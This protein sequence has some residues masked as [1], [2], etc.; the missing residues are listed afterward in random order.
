MSSRRRTAPAS[1]PRGRRSAGRARPWR[2]LAFSHCRRRARPVQPKP[3][4]SRRRPARRPPRAT[5]S[6]RVRPPSVRDASSPSTTLKARDPPHPLLQEAPGAAR[7]VGARLLIHVSVTTRP[8]APQLL[9][10]VLASLPANSARFFFR[11]PS[12]F[13]GSIKY[14][15]LRNSFIQKMFFV[16]N[17]FFI[18][19]ELRTLK[20]NQNWNFYKKLLIKELCF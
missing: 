4:A 19:N 10:R 18:Y 1:T 16:H 13:N 6:P 11:D 7:L 3:S 8:R 20:K 12:S 2:R 5:P 9:R 17:R 14:N 15:F